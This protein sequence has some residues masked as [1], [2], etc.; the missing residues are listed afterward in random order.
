ML[1]H[2]DSNNQPAMVD[3]S[4]KT[5]TKRSAHARSVVSLPDEVAALFADGDI[6]SKKGPVFQ[7]AII[8]G[9]MAKELSDET[10]ENV[11]RSLEQ[12]LIN[13]ARRSDH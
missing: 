7:T 1:S 10:G 2:V 3:V 9:V 4:E 5:P 13:Q 11:V 12:R 8:A 6:Q